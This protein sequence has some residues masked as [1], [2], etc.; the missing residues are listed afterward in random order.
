[1]TLK[2]F[3]G[4]CHCSL[5]RSQILLPSPPSTISITHWYL[6]SLPRRGR[7]IE[8][9]TPG[10]RRH[11]AEAEEQPPG[12]ENPERQRGGGVG[13]PY[14]EL[15]YAGEIRGFCVRCGGMVLVWGCAVKIEMGS[16]DAPGGGVG[17]YF[18]GGGGAGPVVISW[19]TGQK[20][21]K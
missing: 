7:S 16:L 17:R 21:A 3:T 6:P 12:Y 19:S 18:G 11:R 5:L 13:W 14:R 4:G 9:Y 20:R 10:E 2:S 15:E 1:M 8:A